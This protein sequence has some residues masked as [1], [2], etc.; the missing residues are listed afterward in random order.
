LPANSVTVR[1][2]TSADHDRVLEL[3]G[4]LGHQVAVDPAK[5]SE[6]FAFAL[7][8][9]GRTAIFVAEVDGVIAGYCL[10]TMTPLLY[11]NGLSAQLQEIVADQHTRASGVGTSLVRA[12][13]ALCKDMGVTQLTVAS[14]RAGGFYDR[15]GYHEAAEYMRRLF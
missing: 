4:Q 12:V 10:V 5:F 9:R 11:T 14:R 8:D 2:A 7:A 6:A 15:L 3:V 1:P 13:E